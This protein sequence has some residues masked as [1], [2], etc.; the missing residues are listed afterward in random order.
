MRRKV[1]VTWRACQGENK[2]MPFGLI[3]PR[4]ADEGAIA[5]DQRDKI[6]GCAVS[7]DK[8]CGSQMMKNAVS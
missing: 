3:L 8:E 4:S 2:E 5:S 7:C 1:V 6:G